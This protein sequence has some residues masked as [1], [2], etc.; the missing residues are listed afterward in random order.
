MPAR[1]ATQSMINTGMALVPSTGLKPATND[2]APLGDT[3]HNFSDLFLATGAVIN[4]NNGNVVVTHSSGI[5][6]VGT[7]DLRVTTAGTNAASVVTVGGT[8]TLTNKTLTAPVIGVATGTS[9]AVTGALSSSS[10]S[11][12]IGYVTGAQ[13]TAVVQATDRTTTVVCNGICGKIT[14]QATS[15]A[16]QES[17]AFTVTN[18]SVALT[19]TVIVNIRSGPTG[20]KTIATVTTV[21][22]GS[23]K[24]N[25]FN[26]DASVAD[27]GAAIINFA[28]IKAA[29]GV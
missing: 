23:F 18:S 3:T 6:T 10:P 27:T 7:G 1:G 29:D 13:G 17:V 14:T 11:A 15:L 24:I 9:L 22:A 4:Y 28:V 20:L 26:T 12:G 2:G 21:A 8:Q 19:D 16:A 25:L 5:L